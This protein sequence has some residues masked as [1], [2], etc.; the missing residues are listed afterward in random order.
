MT[1]RVDFYISEGTDAREVLDV[2]RSIC[3]KAFEQRLPTF[4]LAGDEPQRRALDDWLWARPASGFLP[5]GDAGS[6]S[7]IEIGLQEPRDH[8]GLLINLAAAP[9]RGRNY[10]RIAEVVSEAQRDAGREKYRA[11]RKQ[12]G[13]APATHKLKARFTHG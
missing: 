13:S 4:I 11:H 2:A 9:P 6:G 5:H 7:P 12:L 1:T 8:G 10:A 3:Q